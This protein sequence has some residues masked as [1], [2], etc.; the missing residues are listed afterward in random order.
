MLEQD[1]AQHMGVACRQ[2]MVNGFAGE[3]LLHPAFCSGAMD[4][5]EFGRQFPLTALA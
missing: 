5:G 1:I 4:L 3:T 2:R